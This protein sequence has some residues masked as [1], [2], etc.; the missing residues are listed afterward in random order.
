MGC[1]VP[2]AVHVR[3][4]ASCGDTWVSLFGTVGRTPRAYAPCGVSA[5]RGV[6]TLLEVVGADSVLQLRG[7]TAVTELS[8]AVA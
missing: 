1:N 2:L 8:L 3:Q 4:Y 5:V 7:G 6:Q